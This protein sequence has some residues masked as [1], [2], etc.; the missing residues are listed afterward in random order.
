MNVEYD[1]IGLTMNQIAKYDVK[2]A[3]VLYDDCIPVKKDQMWGFISKSSRSLIVEPTYEDIGC[4]IG[5]STENAASSVI[6]VPEYEGIIVKK[7]GKYGLINST[8]KVIIQPE[9]TEFYTTNIN[10]QTSY[11][12]LYNG[13]RVNLIEFLKQNNIHPIT[14]ITNHEDINEN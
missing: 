4:I 7:D 10:S 2:N 12:F 6:L 5:T 1:E 13:E 9:A 3:Y 11:Y 8:G 14:E